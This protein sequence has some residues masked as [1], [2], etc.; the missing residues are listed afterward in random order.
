MA[1]RQKAIASAGTAVAAMSGPDV[2]TAKSATASTSG[3][4]R[5]GAGRVVPSVIR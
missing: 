3:S 4:E 1:Q 5:V 2:E